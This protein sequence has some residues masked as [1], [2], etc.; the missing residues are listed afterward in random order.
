M[1]RSTGPATKISD[2]TCG[3]VVKFLKLNKPFVH[4]YYV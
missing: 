1:A 3:K 4:Y 2:E